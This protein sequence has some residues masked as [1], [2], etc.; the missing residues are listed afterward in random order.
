M[1]SK[2][3]NIN[4]SHIKKLDKIKSNCAS[5]S[6]K[7]ST[8]PNGDLGKIFYDKLLKLHPE[9]NM[10]FWNMKPSNTIFSKMMTRLLIAISEDE[11]SESD[12]SDKRYKAFFGSIEMINQLHSNYRIILP[13]FEAFQNVFTEI[14]REKFG[15]KDAHNIYEIFD[16]IISLMQIPDIIFSDTDI[17]RFLHNHKF[18]YSQNRLNSN[19]VEAYNIDRMLEDKIMKMAVTSFVKNNLMSDFI[20]HIDRINSITTS[21]HLEEFLLEYNEELCS[22]FGHTRIQEIKTHNGSTAKKELLSLM[23]INLSRSLGDFQ[24]SKC[25]KYAMIVYE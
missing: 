12:T 2:I 19:L 20:N 11:S 15:S 21:E 16:L 17:K 25:L 13:A 9:I 8:I 18:T 22:I 6:G 24:N 1:G 4:K 14:V 23:K 10:Y 3:S 7:L 5:L